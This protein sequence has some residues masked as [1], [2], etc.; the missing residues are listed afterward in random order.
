MDKILQP[1]KLIV[2]IQ[3]IN[4]GPHHFFWQSAKCGFAYPLYSL[5]GA[6]LISGGFSLVDGGYLVTP[7]TPYSLGSTPN[8]Y[9]V[10]MG[11]IL[12]YCRA[13]LP[14][15]QKKKMLTW[16]LIETLCGINEP[17]QLES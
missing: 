7:A 4:D 12:R 17:T 8:V 11:L 16:T 10:P 5:A 15:H 9:K 13:H 3:H 14:L 1:V 6:F 2:C